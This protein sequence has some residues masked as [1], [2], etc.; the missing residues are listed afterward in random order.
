VETS[1]PNIISG[2]SVRVRRPDEQKPVSL[3]P[4]QRGKPQDPVELEQSDMTRVGQWVEATD[5]DNSKVS[6]EVLWETES[7]IQLQIGPH[8]DIVL[9]KAQVTIKP[10]TPPKGREVLMGRAVR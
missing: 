10:V 4:K 7:I 2:A 6:G 3:A 5:R 8:H 1:K 9:P